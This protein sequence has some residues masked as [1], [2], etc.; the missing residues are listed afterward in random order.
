MQP[1]LRWRPACVL[2]VLALLEPACDRSAPPAPKAAPPNPV[3][4]QP[5]PDPTVLRDEIPADKLDA[6]MQAHLQGVGL[7]EQ[8]NY[9][10]AVTAFRKVHELAPGW[11]GGSVNLAIALFNDTGS[12][13]AEAEKAGAQPGK[14]NFDQALALLAQVLERDPKNLHAHYCRGIILESQGNLADAHKD[15]LFVTEHDPDDA[16]AWLK[17]GSTMTDP[18]NP[19]RKAGP[20]QAKQ[21]IVIYTKALERNPNSVLALYRLQEVYGWARDPA[22]Q[23][24]L[25]ELWNRLNPRKTV[26][27]PG[28]SA[29]TTYGEMG[30]YAEVVGPKP[31]LQSAAAGPLVSPRFDIPKPIVVKLPEGDH[32]VQT[33]DFQGRQAVIGRARARFGAAISAFDADGDGRTDLFLAAAVAGPKGVRDALL[34]NKGD[35]NF[36]D[37]TAALGLPID[38][39]SLGVAASDF[40]AD[41]RVDLFLTGVGGNRLYHNVGPKGF[42][43]IT[44]KAG[45]TG[46][47]AI[48]LTA[49]WLDLDQDGD[50]DL[51]VINYT[52]ADNAAMAFTERT[53]PG[54]A[55]A[56]YRND[57]KPSAVTGRPADNWA[58]EA[59]APV[60]MKAAGGLSIVLTPWSGVEAL[61]GGEQ[62]HTGLA[63]LDIDDDRDLDLVLV[64]DGMEPVAVLNDR[65]GRFHKASVQAPEL[66]KCLS[67]ALVTE[68]DK[69]G[70]PDIVVVSPQGPVVALRNTTERSAGEVTCRFELFPTAAKNWRSAQDVDLDLDGW[71]DLLGLPESSPAPVWARDDGSRL[72]TYAVAL[73]PD[74]GSGGDLQGLAFADLVGDPLPDLLLVRN[75]EAPSLAANLGN[76]HHWVALDLGGRWQAGKNH[77]RSNPK[78]VGTRI[79]L[80]ALGLH[81]IY[82]HT[83]PQTDLAQSVV[84]I[85][86]GLGKSESVALVRVRWPD[87]TLQSELNRPANQRVAL[88]EFN[89]KPD[90]CP[91][92]FTWNGERF[93]CIGDFL[94]GGGLGYLVAPGV[95]NEPDRDEAVA[96]AADQL[97]AVGGT[98]RLSI[99]EPMDEVSYLD[100]LTLD[101][102]D[103]P[104]VYA[105]ALDERFAPSGPRPTGKLIAWRESIA[106]ARATDLTGSTDLTETLRA[107]DR[108]TA[109]GFK[110]LEGWTGYAEEHG[111]V[112]DFGD[113]LSRF[114]PSDPLVLCLAGWVEYPHSHTNYAG[115]TAGVVLK[116]PVLERRCKDGSWELIEAQPG[117]PAGMPRMST[118]DLTGK[119]TGPTC[120][121][122]LRTNMEVYWDQAFLARPEPAAP[123]RVTSLGV[124]TATVGY[125]GYTREVSP[126]RRLP[127]LYDYDYVDPAPLARLSGLLTR[128]GDVA[129]L[130]RTDDD[131]LCLVGPGDEVRLEF[132]AGSAPS[133]PEGWTRSFVLQAVGYCKDANIATAASDTI[134]PLPWRGMPAYPFGPEGERPRD[135]AY[136]AYL[137]N[138]QTR[139]ASAR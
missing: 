136:R 52:S 30:R 113:R 118:L 68:L 86:L 121:I 128:Y 42:E 23:K 27:G 101:V 53:P 88:P 32:W 9:S 41:R 93:V 39:A 138:Y 40:D 7:M 87:G 129:P 63:A 34:L 116:P 120:L 21:L 103:S 122:R 15:F 72:P 62:A 91:V 90:S 92:L 70:R 4:A 79:W 43:D 132:D 16:S 48:S 109:D 117:Y 22:K 83:T 55:N 1:T 100:H 6:V 57:G 131:Q 56:A 10:Q 74:G 26:T 127:L 38:R 31:A 95:Y 107:W 66:P 14:G 108:R 94:G 77:M 65:L 89:R 25:Y 61:L 106:P 71:A 73:G 105:V 3:T 110:K 44:E 2:I 29:D 75:G 8:Y 139:P 50:L 96:V 81:V 17:L 114:G 135:R 28:D 133:L 35:G 47:A 80:E 104:P 123:V 97:R 37:A 54:L 102:V 59:V 49:R 20:K 98:Y 111:I 115:A 82:D 51:Y 45:I 130:L 19:E 76:G 78:G 112:L 134:G 11:I 119:L 12:Q 85:V 58:P 84:P 99:T 64:G 24:E 13:A 69:D 126:D 33:S 137:R 124:G 67:G 36:E 46:T 125:R 60:D 18:S 5:A